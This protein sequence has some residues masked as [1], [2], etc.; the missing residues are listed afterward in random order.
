M[1][2]NVCVCVCV[3]VYHTIFTTALWE[4]YYYPHFKDGKIKAQVHTAWKWQSKHLNSGHLNSGVFLTTGL[5]C[6]RWTHFPWSTTREGVTLV[7][8]LSHISSDDPRTLGFFFF[9]LQLTLVEHLC[10]FKKFKDWTGHLYRQQYNV[11]SCPLVALHW[12]LRMYRAERRW[13]CRSPA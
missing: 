2:K 10:H 1:E 7:V 8:L 3:N 12:T 11:T 4:S 13:P 5:H 9:F 6:L